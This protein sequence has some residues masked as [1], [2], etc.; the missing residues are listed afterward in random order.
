MFAVLG[1]KSLGLM[2]FLLLG[3][4]W[5]LMSLFSL[6]FDFCLALTTLVT[7]DISIDP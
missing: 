7:R 3:E 2:D 6:G 5:M 4:V 1:F